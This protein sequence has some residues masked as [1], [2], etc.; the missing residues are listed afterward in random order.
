GYSGTGPLLRPRAMALASELPVIVEIVDT[1]RRVARFLA[2]QAPLH[3]NAL[4]TLERAHVLHYLAGTGTH[5]LRESTADEEEVCAMPAT[6]EGTL[7]RIFIGDEDKDSVT[8]KPLCEAI[9]LRAREAGLAGATVLHGQMGFGARSRVH[10][11]HLL[12]LSSDLP[13]VIEIADEHAKIEAFLSVIESMVKEGL[14]TM[15][16]VRMARLEGR[17]E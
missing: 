16:G 12:T 11:A 14:V 4:V 10:R 2:H 6:T 15:E 5:A 17:S 8:H 13:V 1:P 3:A 9:V 7:L